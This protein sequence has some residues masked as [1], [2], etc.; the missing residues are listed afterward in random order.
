MQEHFNMQTISTC[1]QQ[2]IQQ[3]AIQ[4]KNR[5]RVKHAMVSTLK[6]HATSHSVQTSQCKKFKSNSTSA[7][8]STKNYPKQRKQSPVHVPSLTFIRASEATGPCLIRPHAIVHINM[9]VLAA[10]DG[11]PGATTAPRCHQP[12][13]C[14][15]DVYRAQSKV[16]PNLG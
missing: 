16:Y 7:N 14:P 15:V 11:L 4:T 2:K 12:A 9:T 10:E 5:A 3:H 1:R 6:E 13:T 8:A